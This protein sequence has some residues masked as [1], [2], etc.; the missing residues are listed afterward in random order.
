MYLAKQPWPK[1][2]IKQT[3]AVRDVLVALD[4]PVTSR[5]VQFCYWVERAP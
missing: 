2:M 5:L 1:S 3:H 4:E